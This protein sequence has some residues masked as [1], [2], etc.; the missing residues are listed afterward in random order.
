VKLIHTILD[1]NTKLSD[2]RL[3]MT[4]MI[5]MCCLNFLLIAASAAAMHNELLGAINL[6]LNY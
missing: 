2:F 3:E 1:W 4:D 5:D 6:A